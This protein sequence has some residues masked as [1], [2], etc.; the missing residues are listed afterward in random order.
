MDGTINFTSEKNKGT[1]FNI[2]I[3]IE[4]EAAE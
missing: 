4:N 1:V 2:S 3:P